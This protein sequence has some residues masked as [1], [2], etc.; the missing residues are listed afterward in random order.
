MR[1]NFKAYMR[2]PPARRRALRERWLAATPEQ[3]ER[4]LERMR[5]RREH[6]H[7]AAPDSGVRESP[8]P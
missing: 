1:Q 7:R 8:P 3:R 5:E 6:Q 2:M 4:M